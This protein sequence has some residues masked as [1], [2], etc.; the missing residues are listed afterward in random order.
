MDLKIDRLEN[1]SKLM[2]AYGDNAWIRNYS[3]WVDEPGAPKFTA[4]H[5]FRV[6]DKVQERYEIR[7]H[8]PY[9]NL[10]GVPK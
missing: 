3:L 2:G 4:R 7:L 1:L 6:R 8:Q 10:H 9:M 5:Q